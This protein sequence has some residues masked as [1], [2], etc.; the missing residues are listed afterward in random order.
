MTR[1]TFAQMWAAAIAALGIG[2]RAE[3]RQGG[4][5]LCV[6]GHHQRSARFVSK[7]IASEASSTLTVTGEG[8]GAQE[9]YQAIEGS[10]M[11][12]DP[13]SVVI[14]IGDQ[15]S[16]G[17]LKV[18]ECQCAGSPG[19]FTYSYVLEGHFAGEF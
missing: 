8:D 10:A 4:P 6:N 7:R 19:A 14:R 15:M 2:S 12:R 18:R 17:T 9:E 13:V 5:V 3:A 1:R 11:A 16:T